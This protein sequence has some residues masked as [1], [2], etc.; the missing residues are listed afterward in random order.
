MSTVVVPDHSPQRRLA[1][2]QAASERAIDDPIQ[3]ARGAR[4]MRIALARKHSA[5]TV[6]R[7]VA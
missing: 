2:V 3:L 5:A 6:L 7:G 4:I 1:S